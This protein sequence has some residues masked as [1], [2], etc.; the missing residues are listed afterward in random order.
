MFKINDKSRGS[1]KLYRSVQEQVQIM[2]V[3]KL[4]SRCKKQGSLV[5]INNFNRQVLNEM[6]GDNG[7]SLAKGS[8]P[9]ELRVTLANCQGPY[10]PLAYLTLLRAQLVSL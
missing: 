7:P 3:D 8:S 1:T 4:F 2:L 10:R 6:A 9:S 5:T